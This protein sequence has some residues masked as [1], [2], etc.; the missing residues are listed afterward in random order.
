MAVQK[1]V[2]I[3][4]PGWN[5]DVGRPFLQGPGVTKAVAYKR[6]AAPQERG[7]GYTVIQT[8]FFSKFS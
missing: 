5:C 3:A 4:A 2:G 7:P 8:D 6:S 1:T